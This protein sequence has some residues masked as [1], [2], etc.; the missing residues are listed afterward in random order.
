MSKLIYNLKISIRQIIRE[1]LISTINI[2]GL[3]IG[4]ACTILILLWVNDEVSYDKFHKNANNIYTLIGVHH[5][6]I[7]VDYSG[8]IPFPVGP[9]IKNNFDEIEKYTRMR[10]FTSAVKL[11]NKTFSERLFY[12]TDPAFFEIFTYTFLQGDANTVFSQPNSLVITKRIAEKYF[13]EEDPVGKVLVVD[14]ND[15]FTVTGV[16]ADPPSNSEIKFDFLAPI[17]YLED[18]GFRI[19]NW[20]SWSCRTF[21]QLKEFTDHKE[22]E[23]KIKNIINEQNPDDVISRELKLKALRDM[24]LYEDSGEKGNIIY[25]YILITLACFILVIACVNFMNLSTARATRRAGEVGLRKVVGANRNKL[26]IKFFTESIILVIISFHLALIFVELLRPAFNLLTGKLLT[27][28]YFDPI[29]IISSLIIILITGLLAGVYPALILSSFSPVAVLKTKILSDSKKSIMRIIL[30]IF[31]FSLSIILIICSAVIYMQIM[32][33]QN[34][35]LGIEKE[36]IIYFSLTPEINNNY[37]SFKDEL[38]QQ[39]G[40]NNITRTFQ[41][42]SYNQFQSDGYWEGGSDDRSLVFDISVVDFDYINSFGIKISEG[43]DFDI[44]YSTDTLNYILNRKAIEMMGIEDPIGKTF[45]AGRDS[46]KII[47]ITENYHVKPLSIDI[48]PLMLRM[49]SRRLEFL[50]IKLEPDN[51]TSTINYIKTIFNRYSP[52]NEPNIKFFEDDYDQLYRA[53]NRLGKLFTYFTILA[54]FIS[55]LGLYGLASFMAENKTKE[56]GIRKALGSSVGVIIKMLNLDFIKWVVFAIFIGSPLAWLFMNNWL[57]NF[58]YHT[59]IFWWLF[60]I[61]GLLVII[62]AIITTSYQAYKAATRNPVDS[63]RHE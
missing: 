28:N 50:V 11:N 13:N 42:P 22:F 33:I 41:M 30:V 7:G 35:D 58:V 1:K 15:V 56:I 29:F 36:N 23:S 52:D 46:G 6:E 39:P 20:N 38:I 57:K 9:K 2:I 59:K 61:T 34:K 27:I 5:E 19:D 48:H 12:Y 37:A 55:C 32:F 45:I 47:G 49:N 44:K 40:V 16:I 14:E 26:I 63:L 3:A 43:R 18:V 24:H 8:N 62:I 60:P 10:R 53:E 21:I 4:M 31:Q 51:Q 17:K 25:V 54:I